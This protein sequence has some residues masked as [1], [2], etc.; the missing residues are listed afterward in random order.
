VTVATRV[1]E[2]PAGGLGVFVLEPVAEGECIRTFEIEREVTADSPVRPEDGEHP[3]H[4][5]FTAGRLWLV[6]KPER[7]VNHSCDPNAYLRVEGNVT[8]IVARRDI[9]AGCELT[10]DYLINNAGGN[11]WPCSCGAERC[12]GETGISFFTLPEEI[13]R[14]YLPLLTPDFAKAHAEKLRHLSADSTG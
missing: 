1:G 11:S 7:Y 3:D 4:C 5:V 10:F 6:A 12:R 2:S 9:A 13:Q 14:E 8:E